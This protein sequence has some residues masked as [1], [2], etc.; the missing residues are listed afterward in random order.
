MKKQVAGIWATGDLAQDRTL[1]PE[2]TFVWIAPASNIPLDFQVDMPE[3][4]TTLLYKV[5]WQTFGDISDKLAFL[6]EP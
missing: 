5:E 1:L 6:D 2:Y 4:S 3:T